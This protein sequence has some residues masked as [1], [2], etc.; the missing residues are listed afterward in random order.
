[1]CVGNEASH[2][3]CLC[4]G[5][6]GGSPDQLE[7]PDDSHGQDPAGAAAAALGGQPC[8]AALGHRGSGQGSCNSPHAWHAP[9]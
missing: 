9:N 2:L 4:V 3:A 5:A 8:Q 6:R 1:M 7:H